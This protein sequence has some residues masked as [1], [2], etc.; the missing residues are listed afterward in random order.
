MRPETMAS[1]C[2]NQLLE[3]KAVYNNHLLRLDLLLAG[4]INAAKI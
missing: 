3:Q 1:I 4:R 2:S